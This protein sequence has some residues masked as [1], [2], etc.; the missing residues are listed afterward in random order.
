MHNLP[1]LFGLISRHGLKDTPFYLYDLRFLEERALALR[2]ALGGIILLYSIKCNPHPVILTRLAG[3]GLGMDAASQGEVLLAHKL[4]L[5]QEKILYSAPGK[6]EEDLAA[7]LDV[8]TI[9]A[10]SYGELE[11]LEA[12]CRR[13]GKK[14]CVGLRVSPSLSFGPGPF[15]EVLEGAPD[16]FGVPE[17]SLACH[18]DFLRS[19]THAQVCGIH[20]HVRSQVLLA[21]ALTAAFARVAG[22]AHDLQNAGIELSFVNLGGGLGIPQGEE[23]SE[24]D[25]ADLSAGL[26]GLVNSLSGNVR[27][28]LESGRY[29]VGEAGFFV[30]PILDIK[31]S[32]GK[33]FVYAP[34]LLN[35]Y[36]R[37]SFAA[38][39]DSLPLEGFRG[40]AEPLW[41]GPGI[42]RPMVFGKPAT[43]RTVTICGTLCTAN[44]VAARDV[45]LENVAIG[46]LLVFP[47]AGAYASA[48]SFHGFAS[49]TPCREVFFPEK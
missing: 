48:L 5:A 13:L 17:E 11:R 1:D 28:Y 4:G 35:H 45:Y 37:A 2:K 14:V 36:F 42:C 38:F 31:E 33:T 9:V 46:N 40:P 27:P 23:E 7:T 34:G 44:D 30:T 8:C 32:R 39:M 6:S 20:A 18:I 15:P 43:G 12:L 47:G 29:L 19:L 25:L 49:H 16:K 3:L 10:D 22:I 41:S 21:R 26:S 24:L